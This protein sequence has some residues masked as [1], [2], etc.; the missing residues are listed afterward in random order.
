VLSTPL[1]VCVVVLGRYVPQFSF[2]HVILGDETVLAPEA[3]VYQR[4]LAMDD[5]EAR[6]VADLYA[7]EHSL[8]ELYDAVIIPALSMAEQDRHKGTLE[9]AR[10]D[11]LFL[12]IKEMVVELSEKAVIAADVLPAQAPVQRDLGGR[13]FVVP[14]SDEADEIAAA[15]LAQL[16]HQA[17][18]AA[19]PFPADF[20]G[21]EKIAIVHPDENDMFCI[22]AV[23]P[24]AFAGAITLMRQLHLR[25]PRTRVMV[26]VWGFSGNTERAVRRFHPAQPHC[27]VNSLAEALRSVAEAPEAAAPAATQA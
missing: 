7:D 5:Q 26:G 15:M 18:H 4:L 1:T 20:A 14:A 25:F 19:V 21:G 23:P 6:A 16:L 13:I 12:S 8:A 10:R 27:L 3:R 11:F 9:P 24:F 17:G 22:S 2:L